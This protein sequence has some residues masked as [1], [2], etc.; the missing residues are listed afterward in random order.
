M[1]K[2]GYLII[3]A[4]PTGL[5]AARRLDQLGKNDWLIVEGSSTPGGL[6]TSFV[7]EMGFTWDIGGHVQFSHYEYFDQAMQ[8][9]LGTDGWY[10]HQRESW[11]WMRDRFIPY[12][13]QNNIHRLP[14]DDLNLCL[15]GLVDLTKEHKSKPSNFQE[16]IDACFGRG[17]AEVFMVPYNFKVWAYPPA[18]MNAVWVGERVATTDLGRVL[19]NLVYKTDDLSW[20]PNNTF[21]FPKNGGTGSIWCECAKR[22]SS[23]K[24]LLNTHVQHIDLN[25]RQVTTA[26]GE[27]FTY[28][29]LISTIPL[30]E[31]I[32][33]SGQHQLKPAAERGLLYSSSNIIGLGLRGKPREAL[34]TKC[35][36]YFPED[37]CPFY[38]ATVFSNY[39][40]N[41]VPDINKHWSLMLEVS[42][43]E[44]KKVNQETLEED[45]IRGALNTSL[46][47]S[48]EEI[49]SKW[50]YRAKYGYPTP[51]LHRDE[52]LVEIIP[53]FES[54]D[55][56]SRGRFGMWKY[57]V[58][59]QDH[60]FMQ[61]VEVVERLINGRKEITAFDPNHAN[62]KKH[63]WPFERW[64][65]A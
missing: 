19:K 45:V 43:S 38:R 3:G 36:M 37:N 25:K 52:A 34:S 57:E 28:E 8:E 27:I 15:Q 9:F 30:R 63:P 26:S 1:K 62:A 59:N 21:Q 41:N 35:W 51:G 55:V 58:S 48:H 6:A 4:G 23:D 32:E 39:S 16:W 49:I 31:L 60:S 13:F 46:I 20:G 2:T 56:Y 10:S 47:D 29:K 11:V 33:L 7:D 50:N 64:I 5:G 65:G 40:P 17:V 42:E 12:P 22:L 53:F 61:G 14:A 44:M 24:M 18:M 54:H